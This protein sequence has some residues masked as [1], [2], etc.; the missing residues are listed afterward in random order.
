MTE[1]LN[2]IS[3]IKFLKKYMDKFRRNIVMFYLGCLFESIIALFLPI[4]FGIMIDEVVYY[5]NFKVF[6]Q[7]TFFWIICCLLSCGLYFLIYSQHGYLMNMFGFEIKKDIFSHLQ[8][9]SAQ[10]LAQANTGEIM[11]E[12]QD[13]PEQCMHFIIRNIIHITNESIFIVLYSLYLWWID[14]RV[15]TIALLTAPLSTYINFRFKMQVRS[16]GEQGREYYQGY[17]GWLLE[18]ISAL[19]EIR[20]LCAEEKAKE[21]FD[22]RQKQIF[23]V[24]KNTNISTITA[25]NFVS[26]IT[27]AIRISLYIVTAFLVQ[28][29]K[30]TV[31]VLTV[32][33]A[34]YEKLTM[35]VS[36]VS[37]RYLDMGNRIT[38]IQKIYDFLN[39]PTENEWPGKKK[40]M[41]INGK[42][43]F[44]DVSFAY[45][46]GKEVL[47]HINLQVDPGEDIALVGKSGCGK[48]TLAYLLIGFYQ[49]TGGTIK[50]DGQSLRE[51][52]LKSIRKHIGLVQQSV[53]I[54]SGTIRQNILLGNLQATEQEI[55]DACKAAGIWEFVRLLPR[56]LDTPVG[57]G[58][59]ELSGGQKQRIAIAR[60]YLRNPKIIIFDEA[61]SALDAETE[62]EILISWKKAFSDKTSIVISHRKDT[63]ATCKRILVIEQ[64][65]IA[66]DNRG[67]KLTENER[68]IQ[69]L[70]PMEK[71]RAR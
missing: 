6:I 25:Q 53:L 16:Y 37:S 20:L 58:G 48:T 11:T 50:I 23:K 13:Y 69:E 44:S 64:G 22:A 15:G 31:G 34:F 9:C 70:F 62:K 19:K 46:K 68:K 40:L 1:K 17:L 42:I 3:S 65:K 59:I 10:Y 24:F 33:L 61:T 57:N 28:D 36:A 5:Q 39:T 63:M 71:E 18:R 52:S 38:Y 43:E 49:L 66:E 12:L 47:N 45:E 29:D 51:C 54:F 27:V 30:I 7:L 14:W 41:I 2:Y 8:K 35:N 55:Y 4:V 26:F 67:P 21:D 56:Q 60:I 32:I